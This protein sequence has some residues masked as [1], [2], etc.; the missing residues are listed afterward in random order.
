M[1]DDGRPD[2][3]LA[4]RVE[5]LLGVSLEDA[6]S[7]DLGAPAPVPPDPVRGVVV[8]DG[9]VPGPH[10][11][12]GVRSYRPAAPSGAA[13]VWC[14]GGG[15][16]LGGLDMVEADA[17][18]ARACAATDAL[19]VSV[20][21]RLAPTHRFPVP[22]DDVE[23]VVD[24]LLLD[25]RVDAE[26]IALGGASAGAQLAACVAHR[27]GAWLCALLLAYP[28][29]DPANGPYPDARPPAVP[30]LL[31]FD[32]D[33]TVPMFANHAGDP[34][35]VGSVPAELDPA[36][37]PPTLVTSAGF[38]GLGP[39][40]ERYGE[41]LRRAGVDVTLHREDG[42]FHGYLDHTGTGVDAVDAALARHLDWLRR[43]LARPGP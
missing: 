25:D 6:W 13:V 34:P 20:D 43:H 39:Q 19:V 38:D 9:V 8:E 42:L 11:D 15:W 17:V 5:H 30:P 21:Y 31:W 33:R 24:A 40:A 41:R 1:D 35:A 18:A 23:A 3:Q 22:Q 14:H 16:G 26:R 28:V 37:L 27:R 12:V 10:G 32:R 36:D 4:A 29:T 2:E 7:G